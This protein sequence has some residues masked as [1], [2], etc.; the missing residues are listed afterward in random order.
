MAPTNAQTALQAQAQPAPQPQAAPAPQPQADPA[1][2]ILSGLPIDNE[3][4]AHAWDAFHSATDENDL[5]QRLQQINIPNDAKAHLWDA[6]KMSRPAQ[7]QPAAQPQA[8]PD[9][10]SVSR[11]VGSF[12]SGSGLP[13]GTPADYMRNL[14]QGGRYMMQHP[15]DS[16]R[17]VG[18]AMIDAQ[19]EQAQKAFEAY[20]KGNYEEAIARAIY[21]GI[22]VAGP[23]L[24]HS[25]EQIQNKDYAGAAGTILSVVMPGVMHKVAPGIAGALGDSLEKP[26]APAPQTGTLE[27]IAPNAESA[28]VAGQTIQD[29]AKA[30]KQSIGSQVGAAQTAVQ[31]AAPHARFTVTP[32]S[33]LFDTAQ[34][35]INE[36]G[37]KSQL[38][39]GGKGAQEPK[40]VQI[41]RKVLGVDEAGAPVYK[42]NE[43][44]QLSWSYQDLKA[45]RSN[46][47]DLIDREKDANGNLTAE[48]R[49][50]VQLKQSLQNDEYSF[51]QKNA[52]AASADTLK[53]LRKAYADLHI[54]DAATGQLNNLSP[55]KMVSTIV[56]QGA[57]SQSLI[58][59][60]L[61]HAPDPEDHAMLQDSVLKEIYRTN[62]AKD[63]PGNVNAV[64]AY[65]KFQD[66]GDA[67][68]SLFGD[69]YDSVDNLLKS[70]ADL[71]EAKAAKVASANRLKRAAS[72]VTGSVVGGT[73]GG[74]IGG[75]V[76]IGAGAIAGAAIADRIA[77]SVFKL[78]RSGALQI[79]ISPRE[80]ITLSPTDAANPAIAQQVKNF[81]T[82]AKANSVGQQ[83]QALNKIED[84]T[85]GKDETDAGT[86]K[87]AKTGNTAGAAKPAQGTATEAGAAIA[88]AVG[89]K[90]APEEEEEKPEEV[91]EPVAEEKPVEETAPVHD[92]VLKA[93]EDHGI[94][95]GLL[96]A[97]ARQ[98]SKFDQNA[99]SKAGARG[100]MQL[101]PTTAEILGVDPDKVDENIEG[102]A[103]YMKQLH[104]QFKQW[105]KALAAYNAGPTRV[106][107]AV[108]E[109]GDDWLDH[110][111]N[112]TQ[113]YVENIMKKR[114]AKSIEGNESSDEEEPQSSEIVKNNSKSVPG[115]VEQG[116][117][118][119]NH[120][121][122]VWNDDGSPS[123]IFSATIP[124]GNGK[125]ALVP[126]IANGKFLTPD[127][128]IP[129]ESDKKAMAALEDKAE[130]YYKK[131]GEHLGIFNSQKAADDYADKTHAY[132][133][134]G[135]SEKVYVSAYKGDSNMPLT[136]KEYE[137][138]LAKRNGK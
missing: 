21:S 78:D 114:N 109:Y 5:T 89:A 56:S 15:A 84:L 68:K 7:P 81:A 22:P 125:W 42:E 71:Q 86:A 58:E 118:D 119:V 33:K 48:G 17:L 111:P 98:E 83:R 117:I 64:K 3:T 32:D 54:K 124:I 69:R 99:V 47:R 94:P 130:E 132:M 91:A 63:T 24:A 102:G 10:G 95:A 136:R 134:D 112:E 73:I 16:V 60:L 126:T 30:Q 62:P 105:D 44:A 74:T 101:E 25:A 80:T 20:G 96:F 70:A 26:N 29:A 38:V 110:L 103:R 18:K 106:K 11:A 100:V 13:P 129:K 131:T 14:Y 31:Q 39:E 55:E 107:K 45:E 113:K 137:A 128:K 2:Q 9:Q 34:Q 115:L 87:T 49:R 67:G 23:I 122:I 77:T 104:E 50:L 116:N 37:G 19:G 12:E 75:P 1:Q 82:A 138:E 27:G 4:K 43:P 53:N 135:S 120:R 28:K 35:I 8:Q 65:K 36:S 59:D 61:E 93:A 97:Q 121:P 90:L 52:D 41:A 123:T 57:R 66:M 108:E 40:S 79:G 51:Y 88:P 6:K 92:L 133:P 85:G 127:G 72:D 76:G 46:L